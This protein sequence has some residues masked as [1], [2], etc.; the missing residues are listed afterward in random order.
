[1][2][3]IEK[4][5][6]QSLN[7]SLQK[8]EFF[9][10]FVPEQMTGILKTKKVKFK[11]VNLK[12]AYLVDIVHN[13]VL[14]YH[15][16]KENEF[17]LNAKILKEKYGFIYNYYIDYLVD[18]QIIKRTE[19]HLAGVTSRKYK[20][21]DSVLC[22]DMIRWKNYD[23]FLI[24]KYLKRYLDFEL[25]KT[26]IIP[27]DVKIK[28]INDLYSVS[29]DSSRS[30]FFLDSLQDRDSIYKRNV[31]SVESIAEQHIFYHFDHYGRMHTNFTILRSFIRKT[32][33]L[34]DGEETFEVDIPNSQPMFLAKLIEQSKTKWVKKDE[35]DFFKELL[36]FGS[37]YDFLSDRLNI[38]RKESKSLTYKVLF[39]KNHH[40]SKADKMFKEYFPTIHNFITLYKK[41]H[42]DYRVLAYHLQK[43]ESNLVYERIIRRIIQLDPSI[44]LITVHDSII[45]SVSKRT[46]VESIFEDELKQYFN[47]L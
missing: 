21:D 7:R 40:N 9:L 38:D 30:L 36:K 25:E 4:L 12:T 44:K 3:D 22:Q 15:F 45:S 27:K 41:E 13:M 32:C 1:M 17:A 24:K 33:L 8:K 20:I 34:I 31:Y 10:Q 37:F 2:I 23:K 43:M 11:N 19:N 16:K 29:I 6:T 28:L 39:G 5:S 18:N 42:K 47:F 14:K 35:F 26:D 46:Q